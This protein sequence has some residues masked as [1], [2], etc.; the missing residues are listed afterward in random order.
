VAEK[1]PTSRTT[2]GKS[3][4]RT[5]PKK[6]TAKDE[7][8]AAAGVSPPDVPA[9]PPAPSAASTGWTTGGILVLVL[10]LLAV[11]VTVVIG[12]RVR[13]DDGNA[14]QL[15]LG[16][17]TA[18][19]AGDLR[20]FASPS[21]PVY[22]IGPANSGTLE[23]TRTSGGGVYVRYLSAGVAVGDKAASYTTIATYFTPNA[24]ATMR[25]SARTPGFAQAKAANGSLAVWRIARATSVYVA[26]PKTDYLVEVYDPSPRRARSLALSTRLRR[27][28]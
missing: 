16:V 21:R 15:E 2:G 5:R 20:A 28:P 11:A 12:L 19:S 17:P 8:P 1:R 25:R 22:W 3:A 18:A 24:Y 27:V 6:Q 13:G 23:V 4:P 26:F 10:V 14:F 7:T 9:P